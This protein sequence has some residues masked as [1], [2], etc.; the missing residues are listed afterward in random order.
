MQSPMIKPIENPISTNP[1]RNARTDSDF[2]WV[3]P[4]DPKAFRLNQLHPFFMLR[5]YRHGSCDNG[6]DKRQ[7]YCNRE[8]P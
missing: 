7:T 1:L 6:E 2:F 4:A 5:L 8:Y 3:L